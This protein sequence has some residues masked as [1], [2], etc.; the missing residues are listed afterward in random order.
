MNPHHLYLIWLLSHGTSSCHALLIWAMPFGLGQ[1]MPSWAGLQ[2]TSLAFRD[3]NRDAFWTEKSPFS[4]WIGAGL[5]EASHL[6]SRPQQRSDDAWLHKYWE[7][8]ALPATWFSGPA[9][10]EITSDGPQMA[11]YSLR[12]HH[13]SFHAKSSYASMICNMQNHLLPH[14]LIAIDCLTLQRSFTRYATGA[15]LIVT[16]SNSTILQTGLL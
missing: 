14:C 5:G 6:L 4:M 15:S 13:P 10:V 3:V 16:Y 8:F 9:M 2:Q 1:A 12:H 11:K 7:R